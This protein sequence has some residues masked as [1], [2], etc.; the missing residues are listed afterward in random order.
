MKREDRRRNA[1]LGK[2]PLFSEGGMGYRGVQ[3]PEKKG[4]GVIFWATVGVKKQ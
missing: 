3:T 4:S 2:I 1:D